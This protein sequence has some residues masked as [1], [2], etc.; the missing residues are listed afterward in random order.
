LNDEPQSTGVSCVLSVALRIASS[1]RRRDV[2]LLEVELGD[3]VVVDRHL[4]DE[5]LARLGGLV[6]EL[7]G[8]VD[9]VDVLARARPCT[10]SPSS[11]RG[12]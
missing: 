5:L 11:R 9:D 10:G 2:A 1:A 7:R 6:G 8:D 4:V 12:R 3:L